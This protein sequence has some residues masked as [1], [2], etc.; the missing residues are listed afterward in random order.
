V[1][2]APVV[3]FVR[4]GQT[5]WNAEARLQGQ[6]D[7][8]LND[9]GRGQADRNG[10]LLKALIPEPGLFDFVASPLKRTRET[11]ERLRAAMGLVPSA[12]RTDPRLMELHY[13]GWEGSTLAE[14]EQREPGSVGRRDRDK[15][16]FL[17]PGDDAESYEKLMRRV[18][19]W[20]DALA[21]PTVCVTH[22]GIIRIV[23]VAAE[24]MAKSKAAALEIPQDRVLTLGEG[25]LEWL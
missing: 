14:I 10:A 18:K 12:Y 22:G 7:T 6:T 25:R 24:G 9:V 3:Y 17:P 21:R 19:P 16:N 8:E 20:L 23:F 1:R 4:H 11:M 5:D 13:G 15:W 2:D